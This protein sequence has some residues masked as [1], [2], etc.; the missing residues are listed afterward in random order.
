MQIGSRMK[1]VRN[2]LHTSETKAQAEKDAAKEKKK[3]QAKKD[4]EQRASEDITVVNALTNV[5]YLVMKKASGS[6][7]NSWDADAVGELIEAAHR[8][9]RWLYESFAT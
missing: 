2:L 1:D 5:Y 3:P 8:R 9:S 4:Q 6:I 7:P